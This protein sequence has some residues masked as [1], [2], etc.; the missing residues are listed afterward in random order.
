LK[1]EEQES[2]M[3]RGNETTKSLCVDKKRKK[4]QQCQLLSWMPAIIVVSP[5]Q[6]SLEEYDGEQGKSQRRKDK[7]LDLDS[8]GCASVC[9][10]DSDD[11]DDVFVLACIR[12]NICRSL[13]PLSY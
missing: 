13:F 5:V 6:H 12:P 10:M 2:H 3:N 7:W 1:K 9:L 4:E 11:N 8:A